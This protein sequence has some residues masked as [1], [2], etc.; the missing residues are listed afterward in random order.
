[1]ATNLEFSELQNPEAKFF[2]AFPNPTGLSKDELRKK[3]GRAKA[4]KVLGKL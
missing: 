3:V 2:A 1:M 4:I